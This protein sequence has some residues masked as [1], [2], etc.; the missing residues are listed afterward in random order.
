V[1]PPETVQRLWI[2]RLQPGRNVDGPLALQL[3]QMA[4]QAGDTDPVTFKRQR[5]AMDGATAAVLLTVSVLGVAGGV[6]MYQA[7]SY[8]L[9]MT[10]SLA[11]LIPCVSPM[12]CCCLGE[13]IGLWCVIVLLLPGVRSAFR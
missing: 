8:P 13:L 6:R 2:E 3:R 7:R 11:S 10:G 9:A 5:L 1:T 12:S 4:R